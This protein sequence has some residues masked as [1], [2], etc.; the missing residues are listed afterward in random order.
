MGDKV[1]LADLENDLIDLGVEYDKWFY[2]SS[3]FNDATNKVLSMLESK[4]LIYEKKVLNGLS[5]QIFL[6]IKT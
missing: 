1:S 6:Q 5:P 2:E 3:L 4:K